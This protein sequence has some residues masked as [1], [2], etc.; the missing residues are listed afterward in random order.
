MRNIQNKLTISHPKRSLGWLGISLLC[1]SDLVSSSHGQSTSISSDAIGYY[2][3][4]I[5]PGFQTVSVSLLNEAAF[6]SKIGSSTS[7]TISSSYTGAQ[8]GAIIDTAKQYYVEI[9]DGPSS[10]NDSL[11][12]HRFEVDEVVTDIANSNVITIDTSSVQ[13]TLASVPPLTDYQLELREHVTM[14]GV[15]DK[16]KFKGGANV[17]VADQLLIFNG[18]TYDTYYLFESGAVKLWVGSG[19][20]LQDNKPLFPSQG[21]LF[22]R[23]AGQSAVNLLLKGKVR[24]N[25][26]RQ[27]LAAGFNLISE[28]YPLSTSPSNRNADP[29]SFTAGTGV[30]NADQVSVFNGTIYD[31]Y[32]LYTISNIK[33]WRKLNA[34]FGNFSATDIFEYNKAVFMKRQSADSDYRVSLPWQP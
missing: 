27:P 14:N 3:M 20:S 13:N 29:G 12:G 1:F 31:T 22:K 19:F 17:G 9:S 16:T 5:N 25:P 6:T 4:T 10:V 32:Y 26:F 18:S 2:R 28:G 24:A 23:L 30:G 8:L 11:V 33:F 15:F 21:I 7:T 34:G